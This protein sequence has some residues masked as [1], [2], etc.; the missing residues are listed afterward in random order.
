MKECV[1]CGHPAV[2]YN[3]CRA[4]MNF[5]T[6]HRFRLTREDRAMLDANKECQICGDTEKLHID[7]CHDTNKIRGYLCSTCNHG[8]GLFYDNVELLE[9][10]IQY[11][12]EK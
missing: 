7:H 1:S 8:L 9:K 3:Y 12:N 5:Y 2:R 4:C 10:A 6:K 11:L